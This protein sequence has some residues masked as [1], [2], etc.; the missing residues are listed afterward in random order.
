MLVVA[1]IE[2]MISAGVL[3]CKR[4]AGLAPIP[5]ARR[6]AGQEWLV[7]QPLEREPIIADRVAI[8]LG[9]V[10]VGA[11]IEHVHATAVYAGGGGFNALLLPNGQF[12]R[13]YAG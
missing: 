12:R 3:E 5:A 9:V 11:A 4:M 7:K 13:E 8:R 10:V 1:L 6:A 2:Q